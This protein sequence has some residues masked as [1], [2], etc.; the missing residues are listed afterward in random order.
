[1]L[2]IADG[3]LPGEI[4]NKLSLAGDIVLLETNNLVYNSISGHPDIFICPTPAG[5]VVA[6]N[7]PQ[8]VIN[9]LKT[10]KIPFVFG[11]QSPGKRYPD[12]VHY[13]AVVT[14]H[15]IIHHRQFT[16]RTITEKNPGKEIIHVAQ[17]YTKCNL[18]PLSENTFLTSD[19]G[20]EKAL[21]RRFKIY[22]FSPENIILE[23]QKHGFLGGCSGRWKNTLFFTG[24]LSTIPEHQKLKQI[25]KEQ[26][27]KYEE[28]YDGPLID[29]GGILFIDES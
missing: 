22:R 16:D 19:E 24:R 28:L 26:G 29:G 6:P 9:A 17:G 3:R 15:S 7:I 8:N 14:E 25:I 13:N 2:I 20:I 4:L 11:K 1:M 23:G 5:L 27:L 21:H 18:I 10:H 12:S